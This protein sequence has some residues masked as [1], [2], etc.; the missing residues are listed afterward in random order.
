MKRNVSRRRLVTF[1]ALAGVVAGAIALLSASEPH[2]KGRSLRS[3]LQQCSETP[4]METQQLAEAHAALRAIGAPKA[5][6][7]LLRLVKTRDSRVRQWLVEKTDKFHGRF[8]RWHSATELQL[9]GIAGFE[10]LGTNAA[11]AVGELRRRLGEKEF[12]FVTARC[13]ESIGKP[14]EAAL[15]DCLTNQDWQVRHLAVSALAAVTDDVEVYVARIKDRFKDSQPAVRFAAVQAIGAQDN[16]P[17]LAVPLLLTALDDADDGVFGQAA[18]ALSGFGTNAAVAFTRLTN[19][20]DR[21]RSAQIRAALKALPAIAPAEAIPVLSNAVVNGNPAVVGMAL[22]SLKS[23][24]PELALEMTLDAFRSNDSER[25]LRVLSVAA[26]YD[27]NTPGL[28]DALKSAAADSDPEIAKR[29]VMTMHQMV[30]KQKEQSSTPIHL[31]N[32]PTYAGK[33]LGEWLKLRKEGWEL[34]ANAVE[35][36]RQMG[37]NVFPALLARLTCREPVFGLYD[38]DVS[39]EAVGALISLR[40]HARPALPA[41][42]DLM[43]S[44]DPELSLRA[45][46]ATLGTGADAVPCLMKGLTNRSP[47]V[48]QEAANYLTGEWSAQFPEQRKQALP[49]LLKLLG[50]PDESVRITATSGLKDIGGQR[51]RELRER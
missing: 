6:P 29:G 31:R 18:G 17:E 42:T 51:A 13:L 45:M 12:A 49:L 26:T 37:T 22:R 27:L 46:L 20:A 9:C 50:D 25:R 19:L 38:Y 11:P 32:D 40:E 14:A 28:A 15:C 23:V 1:V 48:R 21:G 33:P 44:D 35:A 4:L 3:W 47:N 43:D 16:A 36:L 7:E 2:H 24:A 39:M 34:S 5:L 10:V 41:L 8:F 30:N